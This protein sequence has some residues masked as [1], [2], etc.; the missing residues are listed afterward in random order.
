MYAL[1]LIID[2]AKDT[3]NTQKLICKISE[4]LQTSEIWRGARG[5]LIVFG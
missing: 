4:V 1:G 5:F 3:R 2:F